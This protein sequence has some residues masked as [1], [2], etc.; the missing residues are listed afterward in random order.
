MAHYQAGGAETHK[1][2]L[3]EVGEGLNV[4]AAEKAQGAKQASVITEL[5]AMRFF[6]LSQ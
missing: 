1:M 2:R 5:G 6:F 4:Q 3:S